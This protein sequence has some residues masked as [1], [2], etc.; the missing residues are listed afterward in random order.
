ICEES[1]TIPLPLR[2]PAFSESPRTCFAFQ[3]F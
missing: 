2:P 1:T 3:A